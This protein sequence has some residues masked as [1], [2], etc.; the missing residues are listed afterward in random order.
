MENNKKVYFFILFNFQFDLSSDNQA[1][2]VGRQFR[3]R[4][5]PLGR[6]ASAAE[7]A[8]RDPLSRIRRRSTDGNPSFAFC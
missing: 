8:E 1:T 7:V 6:L 3:L 2:D 4:H 5:L